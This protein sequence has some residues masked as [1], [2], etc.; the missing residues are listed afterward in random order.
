ML[1]I[2]QVYYKNHIGDTKLIHIILYLNN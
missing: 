2:Y 1:K